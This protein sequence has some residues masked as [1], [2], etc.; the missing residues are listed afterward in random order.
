MEPRY[1]S[2]QTA[3]KVFQLSKRYLEFLR[4]QEDGPPFV[5]VGRR[6]LYKVADFENWL[7][8]SQDKGRN[9]KCVS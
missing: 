5:K 1:V 2:T 6:V 7:E 9:R 3:S 8:A 4:T